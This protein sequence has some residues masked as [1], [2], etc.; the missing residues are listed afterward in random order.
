MG[1]CGGA[2]GPTAT[3]IN[4]NW[5]ATLS[6]VEGSIA[7]QFSAAF[8]QGNGTQLNIT[9]LTF[10]TQTVC[11]LSGSGLEGSFTATGSSNGKVAGTFAMS[12]SQLNVGGP[13]LA[14]QGNLSNGVISGSWNVEGIVPNCSGNGTFTIQPSM[15]G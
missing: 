13:T 4:G 15:A 8:A 3:G 1:G 11:P 9:N 14:L 6:N 7:Y 10:T 2:M 12:M 5:T